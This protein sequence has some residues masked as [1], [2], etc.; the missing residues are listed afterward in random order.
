MKIPY[1]FKKIFPN[2]L[3]GFRLIV[4]PIIIILGLMGK[5]NIVLILTIVACLTDLFDGFFAR[6]WS[7][8]SQFGAKLD[9]ISDKVFAASLM[10]SLTGKIKTL[11]I[12][13]ILE[14][15]IALINLYFYYKINKSETLMIGKIKTTS[16]FIC[17]VISFL[18]L[19]FH[20]FYFLLRGFI[21]MT[22][23]LQVLSGISYIINF[24]KKVQASKENTLENVIA[25]KQIMNEK[26]DA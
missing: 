26:E 3:T 25:H 9:A 5:V 20:K 22:I 14:I 2:L 19:Y 23:N 11:W 12:L 18:Y 10:I 4:A 17:I 21:Y 15:T 13:I 7:V 6:K 24:I 1:K 8:S 16:L